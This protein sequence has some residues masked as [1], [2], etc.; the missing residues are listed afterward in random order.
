[1]KDYS[2]YLTPLPDVSNVMYEMDGMTIFWH[3]RKII[4]SKSF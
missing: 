4:L 2:K 3:K 1:M